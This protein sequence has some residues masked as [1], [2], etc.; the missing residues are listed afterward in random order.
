M[1]PV[2]R[3]SALLAARHRHCARTLSGAAEERVCFVTGALGCIGAWVVK[4]LLDAGERPVIFDSGDDLR[5]IRDL[6]SP[7][8]LARLA[9][10]RGDVSD[11][12]QVAAAVAASGADRI[13]HLAGLQVS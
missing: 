5:R 4:H 12:A 7:E 8:Q 2:R 10:V 1:L 13:V 9:L 6:V 3:A 11:G